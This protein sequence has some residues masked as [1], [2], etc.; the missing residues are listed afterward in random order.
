MSKE[1]GVLDL[2]MKHYWFDK[3]KSGEKTHEYRVATDYWFKRLLII[4]EKYGKL[5]FTIKNYFCIF[6]CGY[7]NKNDNSKRLKARIEYIQIVNG[8]NTD[9]KINKD[10][11]DIKFELISESEVE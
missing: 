11:F 5:V 2:V 9:L 1:N 7:P 8:L 4:E 6:C 3:I 10:V